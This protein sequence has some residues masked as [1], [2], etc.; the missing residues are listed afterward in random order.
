MEEST[1]VISDQ[2]NKG[3]IFDPKEHK[4]PHSHTLK[5]FD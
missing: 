4:S 1:S 5:N 3:P 2:V